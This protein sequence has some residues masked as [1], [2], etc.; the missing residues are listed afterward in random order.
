MRQRAA[1]VLGIPLEGP[2]HDLLADGLTASELQCRGSSSNSARDI[3]GGAE[4]SVFRVKARGTALA[5]TEVLAGAVVPLWSPFP[6]QLAGAGR[7]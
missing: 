4:L 6:T 7:C 5:R 3:W 1:G 2:I